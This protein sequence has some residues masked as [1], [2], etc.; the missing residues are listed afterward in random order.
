M[1]LAGRIGYAATYIAVLVFIT[2][3]IQASYGK[4][5]LVLLFVPGVLFLI[6]LA[7]LMRD[8]LARKLNW[9]LLWSASPTGAIGVALTMY[10]TLTLPSIVR[11]NLV[12][13]YPIESWWQ[14]LAMGAGALLLGVIVL[15]TRSPIKDPTISHTRPRAQ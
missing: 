2:V 1:S 4:I 6:G 9:K 7:L 15:L 11:L 5:D 10:G 12:Q 3:P 8:P 14:Y 13:G